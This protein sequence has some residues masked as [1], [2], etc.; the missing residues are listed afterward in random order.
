MVQRPTRL[1]ELMPVA[2]RTHVEI[3]AELQ[4]VQAMEASLAAYTAELVA[5]LAARRPDTLWTRGAREG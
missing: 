3:A 1:G 5:E 4:R 2:A